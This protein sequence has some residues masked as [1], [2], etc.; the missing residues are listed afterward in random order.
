MIDLHMH[1]TASDGRSTPTQLV[2]EVVAKGMTTMAVAD[3]DTTAAWDE[4]SAAAQDAGV[5][6][7]PGIEITAVSA[8][9]DVHMLGYFFDRRHVEL[10]TFLTRQREDRG[11]RL[12]EIGVRL[13]RLGVPVDL[14]R[15]IA[16]SGHRAGRALGRPIAAAALVAAG[17]VA[18]I[19]EAFDKYLAEGRAA[20]IER[21]GISPA[22]VVAL[23]ARAGGLTSMA[24]PGK[25]QKD[26]LIPALVAA[27]L[28]AI[29]AFHPDHDSID[30]ARYRK[31]ATS[32]GLLVTGG[33]DYHGPGSGRSQGFGHVH[34]PR[35]DYERLV[36]R[37]GWPDR[38]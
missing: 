1:T 23:V 10:D 33:S 16:S 25:T 31:M 6:C 27:G 9:R 2:A 17:H 24:H 13:A 14:D 19:R 11:R 36:E 21:V 38:A 26:A 32:Y 8:G 22:D 12:Q 15:A 34:L 18:D 5:T 7:I 3:H 28:P 30:T 29:E 4:V 35:V 37:A 20:F